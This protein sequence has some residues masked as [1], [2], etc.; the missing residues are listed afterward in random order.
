KTSGIA[1]AKG[2]IGK[3]PG[4]VEAEAMKLEGYAPKPAVP[5]ETASG[6]AVECPAAQCAASFRFSGEAGW[7]TVRVQY[8][9]RLDGVSR[10][11]LSRG[12]QMLAEWEAADHFPSRK[13]DGASSTRKT[14][15]GVALRPGD[16]IRIEGVSGG[17][18]GAAFDYVELV[19]EKQ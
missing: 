3:H 18:E 19:R 1:D 12:A 5:W 9:D 13:I 6:Q 17:A 10:F 11:R 8:F 2:R 16:E 4:R 15:T 14:V 7:Y